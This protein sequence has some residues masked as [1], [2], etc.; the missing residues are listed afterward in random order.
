M[1]DVGDAILPFPCHG[2]KARS[3]LV[4]NRR[5]ESVMFGRGFPD[6]I[7]GIGDVEVEAGIRRH[8]AA[9]PLG[10]EA[11]WFANRTRRPP[12]GGPDTVVELALA[13]RLPVP[14][15]AGLTRR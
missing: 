11:R 14:L 1:H 5:R 3:G 12:L 15:P 7:H 13:F 9:Q 2:G 10:R 6:R 8:N 4:R